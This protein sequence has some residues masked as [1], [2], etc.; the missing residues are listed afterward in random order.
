MNLRPLAYWVCGF[1]SRQEH[2]CL[3]LV[4]VVSFQVDV[5]GTSRSLVQ[6]NPTDCGASLCVI[7]KPRE[8]GGPGPN[9]AAE[10]QEERS[11]VHG[12]KITCVWAVCKHCLNTGKSFRTQ[13]RLSTPVRYYEMGCPYRTIK[14]GVLRLRLLRLK[15]VQ[16]LMGNP[17]NFCESR[18]VQEFRESHDFSF[19]IYQSNISH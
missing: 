8:W 15:T 5:S 19:A 11:L 14:S 6:R 7:Y 4:S 9:W 18:H 12:C 3:S 16:A 2:G 13:T 10:P 1:E 17:W